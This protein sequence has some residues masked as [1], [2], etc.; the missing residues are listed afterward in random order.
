MAQ[1]IFSLGTTLRTLREVVDEPVLAGDGPGRAERLV[2]VVVHQDEAVGV[3]GEE[4]EVE[5]GVAD[6][7]V[8]VE[9]QIAAWK[10]A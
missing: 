8:D 9:A 3:G 5:V 1:M 6:R 10:S 2:L 7:G 4:G